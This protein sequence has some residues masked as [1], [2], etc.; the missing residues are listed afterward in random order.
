MQGVQGPSLVRELRSHIPHGQ[1]TK[2]IKQKFHQTE[3]TLALS[4][5]FLLFQKMLLQVES[6]YTELMT[7]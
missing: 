6:H 7:H 5:Q 2:D 4:Y 3:L 1:K